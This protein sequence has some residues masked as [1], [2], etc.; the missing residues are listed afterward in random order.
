MPISSFEAH[1]PPDELRAIA[2]DLDWLKQRAQAIDMPLVAFLI[3]IA[4]SEARE[5]LATTASAPVRMEAR[6]RFYR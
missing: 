1:E 4:L 6:T 2:K 5:E 3:D